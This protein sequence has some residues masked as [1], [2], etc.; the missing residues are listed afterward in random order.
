MVGPGKRIR[1]WRRQRNGLNR[2][3]H[4][5]GLKIRQWQGVL[6]EPARRVGL[7]C[8]V[9]EFV[10]THQLQGRFVRRDLNGSLGVLIAV[11]DDL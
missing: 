9:H 1:N 3:Q 5:L 10:C 6:C 4:L 8:C 11:K 7:K 2:E